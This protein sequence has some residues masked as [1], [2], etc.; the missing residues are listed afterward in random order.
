MEVNDQLHIPA[1]LTP[2]KEPAVPVGQLLETE[3]LQKSIQSYKLKRTF[4]FHI[5]LLTLP[6]TQ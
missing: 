5:Q 3:M 4:Y 6:C 2:G 1:A